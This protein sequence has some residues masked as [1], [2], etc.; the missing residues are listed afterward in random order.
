MLQ[1][2]RLPNH[3]SAC[4][5]ARG[6]QRHGLTTR[7][8]VRHHLAYLMVR[9]DRADVSTLVRELEPGAVPVEVSLVS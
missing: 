2:F 6:L 4:A 5:A 7:A 3:A 9:S 1:T 8:G